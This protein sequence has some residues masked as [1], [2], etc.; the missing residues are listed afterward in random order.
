MR[1][2]KGF[3]SKRGRDRAGKTDEFGGEAEEVTS[4]PIWCS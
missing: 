1:L 2:K 3:Q 4:T